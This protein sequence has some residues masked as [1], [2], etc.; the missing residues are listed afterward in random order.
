MK[1]NTYVVTII[2]YNADPFCYETAAID[3]TDAVRAAW[4]KYEQVADHVKK[5]SVVLK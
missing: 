5:I 4:A 1:T 3:R 2:Y